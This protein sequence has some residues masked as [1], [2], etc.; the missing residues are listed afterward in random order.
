MLSAKPRMAQAS[1][2]AAEDRLPD[3]PG[4]LRTALALADIPINRNSVTAL[5][6]QRALLEAWQTEVGAAHARGDFEVYARDASFHL[7]EVSLADLPDPALREQLMAVPTSLQLPAEQ[8]DALRREAD[9]ALR[10]S[11]SFQRLLRE[12]EAA[13]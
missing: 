11:P 8:V 12:L 2:R 1:I 4:P 9:A 3:V 7:I 13:K 5:A 10:R 6:H